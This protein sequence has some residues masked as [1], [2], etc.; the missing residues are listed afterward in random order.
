MDN[1][2]IYEEYLTEMGQ[3]LPKGTQG[4][5]DFIVNIICYDRM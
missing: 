1:N 5:Y 4:Q 3:I 2:I